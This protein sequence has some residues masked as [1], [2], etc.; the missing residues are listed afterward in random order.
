MSKL[1]ELNLKE[2]SEGLRSKEFT[3]LEV[4]EAFLDRIAA[5][6][7]LNAF[8]GI[9]PELARRAARDA[10]AKLAR[11]GPGRLLGIPI[12]IK[13][14]ILKTGCATTCASAILKNFVS[15]YNATVVSK[16]A[17]EGAFSLG[18]TNMD[19]FAMGSSTENSSFGPSLNP[20]D[21]KR[22][23]G[24]SSGGS[25]VAV[26][27]G[28]CPAALGTDTGGSIRQPASFCGVVGIKPTY[29]RVSRHGVVAYASSL[30]Q[31]GVLAKNVRDCAIVAEVIAG[32]DPLDSTSVERGVPSWEAALGRKV[33]GLR[34]GIPRE[35]FVAGIS[36]G[37]E[38]AMHKAISHLEKLGLK[39]IEINLPHTR[40]ALAAYYILAPAEASSNLARYDGVKF[41]HRAS[42]PFDLKDLYFRSRSEGF[43]KEVKRR[44][45]IGTYVLSSGYY[46]AYYLKA[47]KVRTLVA[48]DF[49]QAFEKKCDLVVCPAA[50]TTAF[51]LGENTQDPLKMYLNDVFTIP[52]NLAGLPGLCLPCGFDSNDLPV[53]MQLVGRPWDEETIFKAAY[54][55][56]ASTDWHRR[57][58]PSI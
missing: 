13:D 28:L 24:G 32:H 40:L 43:G 52:A 2:L 19:E 33:S 22:V 20:W 30:D 26:A 21:K 7:D 48:D 35:Y 18:K 3:S 34:V 31:V 15:P 9:D 46:D 41:G 50:P 56:E 44:I 5:H 6:K 57:K 16:L 54:A 47:Q 58:P 8:I 53:G 38:Q 11:G 14:V 1:T 49:K 12:A 37:V 29:G 55:F 45:M 10:D 23:P 51:L 25:A 4:T 17:A 39:L 36:P 42:E 27:A